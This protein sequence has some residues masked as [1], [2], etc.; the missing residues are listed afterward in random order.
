MTRMFGG[1]C[2][3]AE[4]GEFAPARTILE[5]TSALDAENEARLYRLFTERLP[6]AA[7]V[8]VAHR[9]SLAAFHDETLD[10]ERSGEAVAA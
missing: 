10:V 4:A 1:R 7:I 3:W 9:E 5:A 2:C 6:K 8:S